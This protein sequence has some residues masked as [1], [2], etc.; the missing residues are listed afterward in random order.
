MRLTR[1]LLERYGHVSGELLEFPDTHGL[2]VVLGANEAGKSTALEAVGDGLFG[3][4]TRGRG[5]ANHPDDPRV[6]FTLRG[7]DGFEASF[8]RRKTGRDKL[9]DG[10]GAAVAEAALGRFLAG[11]GRERFH[12]VFGLDGE[13]L[14][15]AGRAIMAEQGDAGAAIL[16]AQTGLNGLRTAME[17]LD[18]EAKTLFGDGRGQRRIST[19]ADAIKVNRRLVAERSVSGGD[20]LTA[21]KKANELE[22]STRRIEVERQELRSEQAR[23]SRIRATAPIRAELAD[24]AD[25]IEALG[26]AIRLPT[27]ASVQFEVAQKNLDHSERDRTREEGEITA[28]DGQHGAL[29]HDPAILVEAEAITALYRDEERIAGARRNLLEVQGKATASLSAVE[30]QARRIGLPERGA[31]LRQRVPDLITRRI[32]EDLLKRYVVNGERML[33]AARAVQEAEEEVAEAAL[34]MTDQTEPEGLEAL[35]DAV[36]DVRGAGPVTTELTK[37]ATKRDT[38]A[39]EADRLTSRLA[40]WSGTRQQLEATIIPLDAEAG[41]L[42]TAMERAQELHQAAKDV[43]ATNAEAAATCHAGLHRL[44]AGETLPTENAILKVRTRRDAAWTELRR[45]LHAG[46]PVIPP[47]L[48]DTVEIL[49]RRA[50]ELT[51]ARH[52]ELARVQDWERLRIEAELLAV[53]RHTLLANLDAARHAAQER[54]AVWQAAWRPA[55]V[56]PLGPPVMREWVRDRALVL[57]AATNAHKA[58]A[59]HGHLAGQEAALRERLFHLLP[60][61]SEDGLTGLLR[62]GTKHLQQLD[63]QRADRLAAVA[64]AKKA[65]KDLAQAH[66]EQGV[67]ANAAL[68]W[69]VEW[70]PVAS[71]LGLTSSADPTLTTELLTTWGEL[72]KELER[73]RGFELRVTEMREAAEA[74]DIALARLA[75]R[76]EM[77]LSETLLREL[78]Q[79]AHSATEVGT[80]RTRLSEARV[81]RVEAMAASVQA[82]TEAMEMLSVLRRAAAVADDSGLRTVIEGEAART[83][84]L[85]RQGEQEVALRGLADGKAA[86][87]LA[88]EASAINI[89]AITGRLNAIGERMTVLDTEASAAAGDLVQVR[90]QLQTME[91]GQDVVGPAQLV[92]DSLVE[93][94]D[95]AGRYIRLRLAHALLRG[96]I[97]AYRRSQQGPLLERASLLFDEL[98]GGRYTRLEQD[99]GDNGDLFIVAVRSDGTTCPAWALSEGTTDQL[100]LALRLASIALDAQA[101]EP[102]PFI[103]DDLLV[104]FDNERAKAALRLLA[105]FGQTTQVILFTHHCHL[106]DLLQPGAASVHQLPR[107]IAA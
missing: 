15:K 8:V 5:R 102:M 55:G 37:A 105:T 48:L 27:D 59:D 35:R 98:T 20:Y 56:V 12:E 24:I 25:Q 47:E 60:P 73:W 101:A 42:G 49:L 103:A 57:A 33:S 80:E 22:Q 51:D 90:Q 91:Q 83:A 86:A 41:W 84:L 28:I 53:E 4:P 107:E 39:A 68:A 66:R 36:D 88:T 94:K 95:A 6:G 3:F 44:E 70:T 31:A 40:L 30:D 72:D 50:D 18:A 54:E 71:R 14:R 10:A 11:T 17:R 96:G 7:A 67:V 93:I 52:R 58:A 34:A 85:R 78:V 82:K 64:R 97:D 16:S 76:L 62:Q 23:L 81:M 43:L 29:W 32:A 19:A 21:S 26:P 99:E 2:H 74:H 89:D 87:E 45:G 61:G 1:L 106:L 92:Q 79:R 63:A 100:F 77:P 75:A 38:T 13:R 9:L 104:N 46:G 69:M 65:G